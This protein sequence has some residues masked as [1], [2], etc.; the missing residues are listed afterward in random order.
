[1][2]APVSGVALGD[3]WG[4]QA[5]AAGSTEQ[6][7]GGQHP[8]MFS[9]LKGNTQTHMGNFFRQPKRQA[10]A[11]TDPEDSVRDLRDY[12]HDFQREEARKTEKL[13]QEVQLLRS[14]LNQAQRLIAQMAIPQASKTPEEQADDLLRLSQARVSEFV[15]GLLDDPSI[16]IRVLPDAIERQLYTN[17][18]NI[19]LRVLSKVV[20]ES[21]MSII[22]HRLSLSLAP[23]QSQ[24]S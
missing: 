3:H 17:V 8:E 23:Q 6:N 2:G 14:Q 10:V 20:D 11:M 18:F 15:E 22:G 1:M 4:G 13:Q 12:L 24:E 5:T 19:L 9:Q 16:N 21:S 7:S